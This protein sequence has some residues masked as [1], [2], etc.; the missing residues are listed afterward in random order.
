MHAHYHNSGCDSVQNG[1]SA[2]SG[3]TQYVVLIL[4]SAITPIKVR[5][6]RMQLLWKIVVLSLT[7]KKAVSIEIR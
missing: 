3:S 1:A 7:N 4:L 6:R 5:I 2:R